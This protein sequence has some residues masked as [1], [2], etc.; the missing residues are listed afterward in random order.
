MILP[1]AHVT[2][3]VVVMGALI[4]AL[5]AVGTAV[6]VALSA[7]ILLNAVLNPVSIVYVIVMQRIVVIVI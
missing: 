2:N 1:A 7:V 5:M 4:H 6:K 3:P